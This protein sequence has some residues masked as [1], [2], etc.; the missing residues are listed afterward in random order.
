MT[1]Q[2]D[3]TTKYAP[4]PELTDHIKIK[5]RYS[6]FINGEFT[7]PESGKYFSTSNPAT[8]E[9]LS[10]VADANKTDVDK[11]VQSA[12]KAYENI[13]FEMPAKE[14]GKYIYSYAGRI[15]PPSEW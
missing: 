1:D 10:E 6:L 3:F 2:I 9:I 8:K 15:I 11:A 5:D 4:A 12:R 7:E 14:R 13:W